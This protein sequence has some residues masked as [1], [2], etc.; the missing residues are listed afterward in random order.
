MDQVNDKSSSKNLEEIHVQ[1]ALKAK[2]SPRDHKS[3]KVTWDDKSLEENEK[4]RLEH[5]VTKK[6]DE[7]KTPYHNY[8]VYYFYKMNF[9]F[10]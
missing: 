4:Y 3:I 1:P 7:P 6:I 9:Y 10:I 2:N 8:E 5:P